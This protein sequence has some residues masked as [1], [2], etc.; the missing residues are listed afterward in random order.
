M[1]TLLHITD[2]F[3]CYWWQNYTT[4]SNT[5]LY[6]S[7]F[8]LSYLFSGHNDSVQC[9]LTVTVCYISKG[10]TVWNLFT[11]L[12]PSKGNNIVNLK[13]MVRLCSQIHIVYFFSN[14]DAV[15][16]NSTNTSEY[17]L[18]CRPLHREAVCN[19]F[20]L[21]TFQFSNF[22]KKGLRKS[23]NSKLCLFLTSWCHI[24]S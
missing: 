5:D 15:L 12:E 19:K 3:K 6:L 7:Y 8:D 14:L 1:G 9:G 22:I 21:L 4:V 16:F 11:I 23:I 13:K 18:E 2:L 10:V 24:F 17:A 20:C